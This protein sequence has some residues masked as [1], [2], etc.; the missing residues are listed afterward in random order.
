MK[1]DEEKRA[2]SPKRPGAN[3]SRDWDSEEISARAAM[4]A[5]LRRVLMRVAD[6]YMREAERW[7]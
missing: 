5:M 2:E 4:R 3:E 1:N 6:E 7:A